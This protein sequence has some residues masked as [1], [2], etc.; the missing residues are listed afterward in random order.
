MVAALLYPKYEFCEANIGDDI[1]KLID[2][3]KK[4]YEIRIEERTI[5][6]MNYISN[7]EGRQ[8]MIKLGDRVVDKV[9]GFEGLVTGLVEYL[10]EKPNALL[11]GVDNTGQPISIWVTLDR[12]ELVETI[13]K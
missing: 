13:S 6:M 8:L 3:I 2:D 9:T 1:E 11:E 10:Y 12:V 4:V 5:S 7:E